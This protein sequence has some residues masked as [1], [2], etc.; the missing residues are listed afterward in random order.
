MKINKLYK[1]EKIKAF[2]IFLSIISIFLLIFLF[3]CSNANEGESI[4]F[5][6][7][8]KDFYSLQIEEENYVIKDAVSFNQLLS[9]TGNDS[10]LSDDIDFS[11]EMAVAA[12]MGEKLTGGYSIEIIDVLKKKDHLEFLIKKEEPGPND[13]VIQTIT[14]PYHV[15]K[16]ERFDTEYLFSIVE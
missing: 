15:I 1:E 16:L 2:L 8:S 4:S 7:I 12:F 10:S 3:S 11:K 5:E 6:T 9:L 13:M 14:S